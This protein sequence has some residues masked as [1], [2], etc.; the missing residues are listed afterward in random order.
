MAAAAQQVQDVLQSEDVKKNNK[1]Q[2]GLQTLAQLLNSS[3]LDQLSKE[4][5]KELKELRERQQQ[6][7]K[8]HEVLKAINAKT[9][10]DGTLDITN[11]PELQQL[12]Q[13]AKELGVNLDPSKTVYTKEERDRLNDN[14][15]LTVE[16]LNIENEMQMQTVSRLNN[17]RYESYMMAVRIMRPLHE[18]NM[19][20]AKAMAGR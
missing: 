10:A 14:V 3:R 2:Y 20:R 6:V 18:A 4:A 1:N 7:R 19:N 8:L 12:L 17:E 11:D 15:R 16:D 13:E 5:A 9:K